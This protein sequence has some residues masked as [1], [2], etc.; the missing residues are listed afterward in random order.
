MDEIRFA[1]PGN[2]LQTI[3]PRTPLPTITAT[4]H[5]N[6]YSQPGSQPATGADALDF[7]L[8]VQLRGDSVTNGIG[9]SLA[10]SASGSTIVGLS[11]TGWAG[12]AIEVFGSGSVIQGNW[13]YG[14]GQG[15][16]LSGTTATGNHIRGNMIGT[17]PELA[18]TSSTPLGAAAHFRAD[19]STVDAISG[20]RME[21]LPP[22]IA[23]DFA[24]GKV[25]RAFAFNGID[26]YV[27]VGNRASLRMTNQFSFQAW[28]HPTGAPNWSGIIF[29]KDGEY[30][31][32]RW[33]D[34]RVAYWID[35][36][37]DW[38]ITDAVAPLNTWTHTALVYQAGTSVCLSMVTSSI[39]TIRCPQVSVI[40]F[41]Q[42][43][44]FQIGNR[45]Q[46]NPAFQG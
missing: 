5:I 33:Q 24:A 19:N 38:V 37:S 41:P 22:A 28:V 16:V 13:I 21:L 17:T 44:E 27:T 36:L 42:F 31:L 25:G 12:R 11:L 23:P 34:G 45:D 32:T 6:G 30:Q 1:I 3:Q 29:S 8:F 18:N 4:L 7:K 10:N 35:G 9:L 2:G 46:D 14:N 40:S 26:D 39:R 20:A 43:N 15:I